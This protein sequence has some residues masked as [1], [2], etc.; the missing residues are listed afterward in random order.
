MLLYSINIETI[1][2]GAKNIENDL[3]YIYKIDSST[4]RDIKENLGL[5]FAKGA[6]E[7]NTVEVKDKYGDSI[8]I[9]QLEVS[10]IIQSRIEEILNLCKKQINMI[11]WIMSIIINNIFDTILLLILLFFLL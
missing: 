8:I 1:N 10:K 3:M 7:D 5:S 9:N 4:A 11:N 2:V 6:R